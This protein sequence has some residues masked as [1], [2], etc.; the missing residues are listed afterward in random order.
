MYLSMF[1]TVLHS[2]LRNNPT[3]GSPGHTKYFLQVLQCPE[4][5]G[6]LWSLLETSVR[7]DTVNTPVR[8]A[9][10]Q[11]EFLSVMQFYLIYSRVCLA[12]E[13]TC[14]SLPSPPSTELF[15]LHC[16][17]HEFFLRLFQLELHAASSG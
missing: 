3:W 14:H 11:T 10:K 6:G 15:R 12:N 4:C 17:L 1:I 8:T 2:I 13:P 16:N 9:H 5:K 7:Y